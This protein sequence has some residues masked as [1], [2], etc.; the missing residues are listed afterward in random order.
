HRFSEAVP[1]HRQAVA[2]N[3]ASADPR[4][5]L[6]FSLGQVAE[7]D[8][9]GLH[10]KEALKIDPMHF[11]AR[12]NLA[13]AFFARGEGAQALEQAKILSCAET[14][15]GFP[16]KAFGILLARAGRSEHA[17]ACFEKHLSSHP[18][19]AD[20]IAMLLATVGGALP[21]R[22]T[23]RQIS[24]LYA[25]Q[26]DRWD[27]AAVGGGGYRGHRLVAVA[28]AEWN[29]LPPDRGVAPG[30]G[31]GLVGELLRPPARHL[32]GGDMPEPMLAQA[33]QKNVHDG[34][35]CGDLMAYLA[36]HPQTCDAIVS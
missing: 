22:A 36:A 28:L 11:H 3:P 33:R 23:D 2:L 27:K 4:S 21:D 15:L 24:A 34:L 8:E 13:L 26:A 7:H 35:H 31:P 29:A 19:D 20:E 25:M 32:I 5:A 18:G 14:M 1:V 16:H 17:R 10:Y 30:C 6:A 12:I 9:A